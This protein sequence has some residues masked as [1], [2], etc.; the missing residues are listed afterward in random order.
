MFSLTKEHYGFSSVRTICYIYFGGIMKDYRTIF[1][2][3]REKMGISQNKLAKMLGMAQPFLSEIE[4][5]KKN[6]SL[7]IFFRICET[8]DIELFPNEDE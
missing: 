2:R 8:L 1:K 7:E 4:S 6:P 3:K 5:G